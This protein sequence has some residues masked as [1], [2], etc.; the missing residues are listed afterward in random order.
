MF[1]AHQS[2]DTATFVSFSHSS[3]FQRRLGFAWP[4]AATVF[5][6]VGALG[7]DIYTT[8]AVVPSTTFRLS[9]PQRLLL[10]PPPLPPVSFRVRVI[11]NGSP[12]HPIRECLR[13]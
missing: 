6:A 12:Y 8:W 2:K 7:L 4:R 1:D 5:L 11:A 10:C 9:P 3:F 13:R